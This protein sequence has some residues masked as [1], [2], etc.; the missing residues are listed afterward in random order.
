MRAI[1]R[2]VVIAVALLLAACGNQDQGA[3][4]SGTGDGASVTGGENSGNADDSKPMPD[5]GNPGNTDGSKPTLDEENPAVTNAGTPTSGEADSKGDASGEDKPVSDRTITDPASI[6]YAD[7]YHFDRLTYDGLEE[8]DFSCLLEAETADAAAGISISTAYAG[9]SGT[10]Y[11]DISDNTAFRMSVDIQ[12]SQYYRITVRHR[13]GSHKE[14]PLL[15][16]GLKAMDI[17][18]EDGEW[19][20]TTV[21]GIFLEKGENSITLGAGWSWFSL[22]CIR[23]EKGSALDETIY[24]NTAETL[25]NP[26]ANR[27]TQNIYQYLRAVYGK[28]TLA[29]QCTN[30]GTNTETDALYLGLGKYPAVRTFD[31]IYD[32]MSF[33]KNR[34]SAKDV[35]LAIDWSKEGGLVVFDWHWYAPYRECAFYTADTSFTLSNAV[36]DEKIALLDRSGLQKLYADKKISMETF[37]LVQDIDNISGL[38]K[39][40]EDENVTVMWRPLHE[41]SGGWFWW[42]ASGADAYRWLWRLMYE[43]M[44]NYHELDNLIWVWNGQDADWYPGDEYCDIAAIDI[45]NSAYDYGTS[46]STLTELAGWAE[47][48]KL[49]TM[50]ECATMPDP[51][52]IVRDRAYWLWFAVW[53]WDFIVVNGTTELSDAFTGFDMMEKVYNSEVIITRDE[54]PDFDGM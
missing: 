27:K 4:G 19:T 48:K 40:M 2:A 21:D 15:F 3:A 45:Y 6:I 17:Y 42:G 36:T 51:E 13:A 26:Y 35:K 10:G 12:A 52:L 38:M 23:I 41:A 32:S 8:A 47:N 29:G 50:S 30:Y 43:R 5:E 11:I 54:L 33:C 14:N 7:S 1:K 49:V 39:R 31:F 24:E 22:D 28:R 20:E 9:Y 16:N 34:P 25:C 44:T 53:N 37:M 46:P 18:S